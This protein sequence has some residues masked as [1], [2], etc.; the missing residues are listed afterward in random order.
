MIKIFL[1]EDEVIIRNGIKNSI[2]WEKEGY[3]FVGEAS[4]GELAFPMIQEKKPDILITDIKMPFMDGLELSQL[5]REE[6]PETKIIILSGYDDFAYAKKAIGIGVNE[7]L[8]K[9]IAGSTLLESIEKIAAVIEEEREQLQYLLQFEQERKESTISLQRRFLQKLA[10]GSLSYSQALE[11]GRACD[12]DLVGNGYNIIFFQIST[13]G[14]VEEFSECI[15]HLTEEVHAIVDTYPEVIM[16][17]R[18]LEGWA[19]ILKELGEGSSLK[20]LQQQFLEQICEK[21]GNYPKVQYFGGVGQPIQRASEFKECYKSASRAFAY[22]YTKQKNQIIYDG[23]KVQEAES[24]S[25]IMQNA[26]H[27]H[28]EAFENFLLSGVKSEIKDFLHTCFQNIGESNMK[29]LIY[30]QYMIVDMY[31]SAVTILKKLGRDPEELAERCGEYDQI[32]TLVS[33]MKETEAYLLKVIETTMDLRDEVAQRKYSVI[34]NTAVDYIKAHYQEDISL[35]VVAS[36]VNVSPNHFSTVF[37]NEM[38]QTFIEFLTSVR[39]D[40]AKELLRSTSMKTAEVGYEVGYNDS[41]YFSYIFKKTQECT[42]R[43]FRARG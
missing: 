24:L 43:E 28:R 42:P 25:A 22:R 35:N 33:D 40:K 32:S 17:D 34:V 15:N 31:M 27:I 11:E 30:R 38:H 36:I 3:E 7:Y 4:D 13:D 37:K 39:M 21:V 26:Q 9:P 20:G 6:L 14:Q 2:D 41:H 16:I 1:V 23:D 29:S 10:R 18:E 19:F 5:V 12:I 8:L